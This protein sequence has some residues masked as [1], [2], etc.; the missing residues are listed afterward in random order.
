MLVVFQ[1]DKLLSDQCKGTGRTD[2]YDLER[3]LE[4]Y[5]NFAKYG[6]YGEKGAEKLVIDRLNELQEATELGC[7]CVGPYSDN[8]K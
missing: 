5:Y 4:R 8:S 7:W 6:E 3:C 2:V 1:E